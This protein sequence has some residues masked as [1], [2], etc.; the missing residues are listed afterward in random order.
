MTYQSGLKKKTLGDRFIDAFLSLCFSVPTGHYCVVRTQPRYRHVH[1]RRK[2]F[3]RYRYVRRGYGAGADR[4]FLGVALSVAV[5]PCL[6]VL[7]GLAIGLSG[8][9]ELSQARL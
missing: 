2:L 8:F 3:G 4:V 1:S 9:I 5:R 7:V 6:D